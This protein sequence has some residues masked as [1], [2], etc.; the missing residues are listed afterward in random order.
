MEPVFISFG[1][2]NFSQARSRYIRSFARFGY[3]NLLLFNEDSAAVELARRE[4]PEI[5]GHQ[6]GYGYWL[7]K[8]YIIEDV[9]RNAAEG[10]IVM[11][12][13]IA[14]EMVGSPRGLLELAGQQDIGVFRIANGLQQQK[15]TK[16]ETFRLMDADRPEYWHDEMV[17]GT[18]VLLRNNSRSR[19]FVRS[20]KECMRDPRKLLDET[21]LYKSDELPGFISHRHDQSILSI[22]AT[23]EGLPIH[24]DPSQWGR[25]RYGRSDLAPGSSRFV[26]KDFGWVFKLHRYRDRPWYRRLARWVRDDLLGR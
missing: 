3:K 20:W 15:F 9:L 16:R 21:S 17:C 11:Y 22:L 24:V 4:N 19:D 23:R 26:P 12:T 10:Q 14:L 25:D 7:W 1:T 2:S 13:D 6:R 8:P 5:F 18:Y